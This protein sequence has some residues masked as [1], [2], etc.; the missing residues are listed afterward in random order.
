MTTAG[1]AVAV[2]ARRA[3]EMAETNAVRETILIGCL[4]ENVIDILRRVNEEEL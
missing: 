1:A 3:I 2:V 4:L